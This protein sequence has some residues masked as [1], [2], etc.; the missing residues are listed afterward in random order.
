MGGS[1]EEKPTEP[2]LKELPK[3]MKYVFLSQGNGHAA[4]I[5][6]TLS[7]IEE[8]KLILVRKEKKRSIVVE[9]RIFERD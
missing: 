9:C 4:I 1:I 7:K 6:S 8:E 2:K 5:S 3:H